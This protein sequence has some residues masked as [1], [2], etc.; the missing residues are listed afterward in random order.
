MLPD[1]KRGSVVFPCRGLLE[2]R[3]CGRV[4]P[5][6]ARAVHRAGHLPVGGDARGGAGE[7]FLCCCFPE[8]LQQTLYDRVLFRP[9]LIGVLFVPN[10]PGCFSLSRPTIVSAVSCGSAASQSLIVATCGS[11]LDG[12]RTLV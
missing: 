8:R 7:K 2:K 4:G 9:A 6:I 1:R 10:C 11:S 5:V 3:A 12:M